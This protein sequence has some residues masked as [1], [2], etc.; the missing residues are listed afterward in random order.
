MLQCRV[1]C[2]PPGCFSRLAVFSQPVP[3]SIRTCSSRA[4]TQSFISVPRWGLPLAEGVFG[5]VGELLCDVGSRVRRDEAVAV[6]DTDKVAFEL[7]APC[8][9]IVTAVL[10]SVGDEVVER[11][12]IYSLDRGEAGLHYEAREADDSSPE[13]AWARRRAHRKEEEEREAERNWERMKKDPR[14]RRGLHEWQWQW[15]WRMKRGQT[16]HKQRQSDNRRWQQSQQRQQQRHAPPVS[17]DVP[18]LSA[19]QR[20][21]LAALPPDDATR[22]MLQ[23]RDHYEALNVPR[24]ASAVTIKRAFVNLAHALHPDKNQ[25]PLAP[26]AFLRLQQAHDTLSCA[27]RRRDYDA[28]R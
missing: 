26:E 25:G 14:F 16:W 6:I 1:L 28:S 15:S 2:R 11:Q 3:S 20:E 17:A 21:A 22:R 23:A 18:P 4:P 12:Q 24:G 13:R 8:N 7:K 5:T 19:E 10:V 27:R 9:G